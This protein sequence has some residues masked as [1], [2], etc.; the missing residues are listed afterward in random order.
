MIKTTDSK[1]AIIPNANLIHDFKSGK[2][3]NVYTYLS[4]FNNTNNVNAVAR[5]FQELTGEEI[6]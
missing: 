4:K 6:L 5:R 2:T 3:Y 1:Y